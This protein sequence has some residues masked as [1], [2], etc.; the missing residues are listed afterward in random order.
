MAY[1]LTC[2]RVFSVKNALKIQAKPQTQ[3]SEYQETLDFIDIFEK[4]SVSGLGKFSGQKGS[5]INQALVKVGFQ[6]S[7]NGV[8]KVLEKGQEFCF[9]KN[10]IVNYHIS[11]SR[12]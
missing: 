6:S 11:H 8:W 3:L 1:V 7:E 5:E 4:F 12:V 9:E 10:L 2:K